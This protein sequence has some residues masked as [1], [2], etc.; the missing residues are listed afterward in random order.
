MVAGF[1]IIVLLLI[2]LVFGMALSFFKSSLADSIVVRVTNWC[3]KKTE[4]Y[5]TENV[6]LLSQHGRIKIFCSLV[7]KTFNYIDK[8]EN[9]KLRTGLKIN[10]AS[11]IVLLSFALMSVLLFATAY[12]ALAIITGLITLYVMWHLLKMGIRYLEGKPLF[13]EDEPENKSYY[14][15]SYEEDLLSYPKPEPKTMFLERN[16]IGSD[17]IAEFFN[18]EGVRIDDDMSIYDTGVLPI[19]IGYVDDDGSIYDVRGIG[20][21]KVGLIESNGN[22]YSK[23]TLSRKGWVDENGNISKGF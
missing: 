3:I 17:L 20:R 1:E 23:D 19:K 6:K 13:E 18:I 22:I 10:A 16:V 7:V 21:I 15:P 12:I 4:V 8:I 9:P 14:T 11:I 5:E 2:I